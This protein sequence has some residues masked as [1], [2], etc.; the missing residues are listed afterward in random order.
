MR[1]Y[2]NDAERMRIDSSG[3][4]GIGITSP[5]SYDSNAD[6]LVIGST[7]ANDKNGITIVGGDTDGRGAIY[8]ADTTQN[9][10]GYIT[11]FHSNNSM[12]FGTSDSTKMR[13]DSSGRVGINVTPSLLGVRLHTYNNSTDAYNIFES[14]ANKWVFGEAG[15]VCQVGGLYGVH[16]GINVNTAGNIGIGTTSPGGTYGKLSVA[17]GI[18][19]L[20]D[21]N[22][23]LEIGRYSSGAPNAYIKLGA[24]ANSLRLTNNTDTA[25]LFTITNGGNVGI[26]TT[27]PATKLDVVGIVRS[28]AAS[29]NYAQLNNGSFQAVGDHGGTFMIDVDNNGTADLVNI[30]KSGSSRFY[31]QNGGNVGIGTTSPRARMSFPNIVDTNGYDIGTIRFYDNGS[32]IFYGIG[33]SDSQFNLRAGTTSDGFAFWAGTSHRLQIQ[34]TTGNVGI[35]TTS[36]SQKLHINGASAHL[37]FTGSN[38]RILFNGFR[39]LEGSHDGATLQLGENYSKAV[40]YGNDVNFG[41]AFTAGSNK[42][43]IGTATNQGYIQTSVNLT[44]SLE[45]HYFYNPNGIVGSISTSGSST[46]Y[47]T[48]SD[49]RL[50]ENV[51]PME[52]ALDRVNDLNPSRFNFIADPENTVDG[53]LA[54]EVAEV[55]PEAVTG[56]KDAVDE[57]GNP[58]YQGIDQSKIVP[59]LVGAIQEQQQIIEDLKQRIL[60]LENNNNG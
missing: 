46:S 33:V 9:S 28:Y 49:Y 41:G 14:S 59:L 36:P 58:I 51:A 57:E 29:N 1:F 37:N 40:L 5:S 39:A 19:I 30:K 34:G 24:N 27:T 12:L 17:G 4:V 22:A 31:I 44:S 56:E 42:V 60:T 13:I 20:D 11:Y 32:N 47:N 38:N 53:F 8:F 54:H 15:G 48:S 43:N 21:N 25:D 50:K 23:K 18:R 6:N 45:H 3:R 2:T 16:S 52:G 7:G 55:I 35:G 10:A 26:G